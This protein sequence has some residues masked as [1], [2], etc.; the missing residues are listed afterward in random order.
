MKKVLFISL[1]LLTHLL[2]L[3]SASE[4]INIEDGSPYWL[5][6]DSNTLS[7]TIYLDTP[8]STGQ[9]L[10]AGESSYSSYDIN[11]CDSNNNYTNLYGSCYDVIISVD[12]NNTTEIRSGVV[13]IELVANGQTLSDIGIYNINQYPGGFGPNQLQQEVDSAVSGDIIYIQP[14]EYTGA[15]NIE[16][17]INLTIRGNDFSD[18][19]I[20][21]VYESPVINI[22]NSY[23]ITIENLTIQDG[24]NYEGAG[25]KIGGS[26]SSNT[27]NLIKINNCIIKDN[28]TLILSSGPMVTSTYGAGVA[29]SGGNSGNSTVEFNNTIFYNNDCRTNDE[30]YG[31]SIYASNSDWEIKLNHCNLLQ[32]STQD[33]FYPQNM[34]LEFK[35][36]IIR[37][38]ITSSSTYTNC[39]IYASS[40]PTGLQGLDNIATTQPM[41]EDVANDDFNLQAGSSL[42]GKGEGNSTCDIS[43]LTN[44]IGAVQ[45]DLDRFA[46]Y[47]FTSG[48]D[49]NWVS[50]PVIDNIPQSNAIM[51]N[52]F[53]E[54][55]DPMTSPLLRFKAQVDNGSYLFDGT[56]YPGYLSNT[57]DIKSHRGYKLRFNQNDTMNRFHGY[58]VDLDDEIEVTYS[59]EATWVGYFVPATQTPADAFGDYMDELY[60]IQHKD[61][62]ITRERPKR[63]SPWVIPMGIGGVLP[64]IS[65]GDMVSIKRFSSS[66]PDDESFK[67]HHISPARNYST[68][69]TTYYQYTPEAEYTPIFVEVDTTLGIKEIAVFADDICKGAVVVDNDLVMIPGYIIELEDATEMEIRA[70]SSDRS[71]LKV[72]FN[73]FNEV[74]NEFVPVNRI[75]KGGNDY[76]RLIFGQ[77]NQESDINVPVIN[78]LTI[79]NYPNP[80]NPET[81]ISF[82]NPKN[83]M[84]NLAIYNI[85]GQLVKTLVNEELIAGVHSI[86]WKGKNNYGQSVASGVYFTRIKTLHSI[87]TKKMVLMK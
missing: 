84:V 11:W 77:D 87:V 58:H 38:P 31:N 8:I 36:S 19:I 60:Y 75:V 67:W 64:S 66:D 28:E 20:M 37:N 14:G 25:I 59:D 2:Y 62:T 32:D 15:I 3:Y 47:S 41:F 45:Y 86:V 80:F 70:W 52:F 26:T 54:Y 24:K 33:D 17:K 27:S 4:I 81:T 1:L 34:S 46:T 61:W 83:S 16:N 21:G 73:L 23:N 82:N 55:D 51:S 63:G 72:G 22:Y 44:D 9:N 79:N 30:I 42:I 65:Y 7:V 6:S 18:T 69:A 35:D 68:K 56:F 49:Y 85:K 74:T 48:I 43:D 50:F 39:C 12:E 57:I 10:I 40:I 13:Y 78:H 76:Y 29:I 71:S 53:A 5:R